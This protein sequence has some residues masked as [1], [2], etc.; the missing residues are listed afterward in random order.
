MSYFRVF[1]DSHPTNEGLKHVYKKLFSFA[2]PSSVEKKEDTKYDCL[3]V[4]FFFFFFFESN[5]FKRIIRAQLHSKTPHTARLFLLGFIDYVFWAIWVILSQIE[6]IPVDKAHITGHFTPIFH[7]RR[8]PIRS[9]RFI[10]KSWITGHEQELNEVLQ[11]RLSQTVKNN[12][13]RTIR[14]SL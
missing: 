4:Q 3:S 13:L 5:L 12:I 10:K 6:S 7:S 14:Y 1:V 9:S 11:L 2:W 8:V